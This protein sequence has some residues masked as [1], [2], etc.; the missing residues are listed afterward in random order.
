MG[1]FVAGIALAAGFEALKYLPKLW[2]HK[3]DEEL[4]LEIE[5]GNKAAREKFG[6]YITA[7]EESE[8]ARRTELGAMSAKL[9]AMGPESDAQDTMPQMMMPT[10]TSI[11]QARPMPAPPRGVA[12]LV[13]G[14]DMVARMQGTTEMADKLVGAAHARGEQPTLFDYAGIMV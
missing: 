2:G 8:S 10:G 3:T 5:K 6:S 4:A 12:D 7:R 1:P 14:H 13:P 11:D 9:D